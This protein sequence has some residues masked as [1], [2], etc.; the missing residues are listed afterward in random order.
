MRVVFALSCS[1]RPSV[2]R[3][4]ADAANARLQYQF[5]CGDRYSIT[6]ALMCLEMAQHPTLHPYSIPLCVA[7]PVFNS[8]FPGLFFDVGVAA[9][10]LLLLIVYAFW[11]V[12][13]T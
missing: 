11:F 2:A 1:S 9:I 13:C 12:C 8:N 4:K 5:R 6:S 7:N 3:Q 10:L